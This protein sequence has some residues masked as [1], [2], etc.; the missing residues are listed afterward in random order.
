MKVFSNRIVLSVALSLASLVGVLRGQEAR[1]K[2]VFRIRSLFEERRQEAEQK[3][4][5]KE[6][7]ILLDD[8][9]ISSYH[10]S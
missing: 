1:Q 8:I 3:K 5:E 9:E 10:N 2:W 7:G 4:L 6:G